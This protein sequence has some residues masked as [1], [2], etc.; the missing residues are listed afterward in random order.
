MESS[1]AP[2]PRWWPLP[3]ILSL[4]ALALFIVW[5]RDVPARADRV[6]QTLPVLVLAPLPLLSCLPLSPRLPSS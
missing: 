3:V 1:A 2:R 5:T 6:V 4:C